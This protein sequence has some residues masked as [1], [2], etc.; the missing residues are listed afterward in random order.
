MLKTLFLDV[1]EE[2]ILI[3]FTDVRGFKLASFVMLVIPILII[4][5]FPHVFFNMFEG[6]IGFILKNLLGLE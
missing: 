5:F 6:S 2:S 3:H 4:G 1:K